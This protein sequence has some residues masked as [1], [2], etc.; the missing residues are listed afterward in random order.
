[1]DRM[2]RNKEALLIT[3]LGLSGAANAADGTV[4]FTGEI[5]TQGCTITS[6]TPLEVDLGKITFPEN[7]NVGEMSSGR[8]FSIRLN[9]PT[10]LSGITFSG[11][12]DSTLTDFFAVN[13]GADGVAVGIYKSDNISQIRNGVSETT[14]IFTNNSGSKIYTA[15]LFAKYI[16]TKD[17]ITPGSANA[18]VN[19]NVEY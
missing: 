1:M 2:I 17:V 3:L 6:T 8:Q 13:G 12:S 19:F 7:V 11:R 9:C 14:G 10:S 4:F 15:T 5:L 16:A 18:S